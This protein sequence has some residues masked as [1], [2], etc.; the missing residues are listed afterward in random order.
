MAALIIIALVSNLYHVHVQ[1][2]EQVRL[3]AEAEQ[4]SA[5]PKKNR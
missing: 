5:T 4:E 2:Q 3:E 1:R